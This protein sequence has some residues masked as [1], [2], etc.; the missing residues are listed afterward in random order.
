MRARL[1]RASCHLPLGSHYEGSETRILKFVSSNA[2]RFQT[3]VIKAQDDIELGPEDP[4]E[5]THCQ[6]ALVIDTEIT[7]RGLNFN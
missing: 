2:R 6:G 4:P 3:P 7:S 5:V 1:V